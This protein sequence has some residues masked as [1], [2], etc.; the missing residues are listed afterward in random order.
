MQTGNTKKIK[1]CPW[2]AT[3]IKHYSKKTYGVWR[4]RSTL[5]WSRLISFMH[6]TLWLIFL[7]CMREVPGLNLGPETGY[8][9]RD[10]SLLSSVPPGKCWNRSLKVHSHSRFLIHRSH[11]IIHLSP[12]HSS[13]Y[14]LSLWKGVAKWTTNKQHFA[15]AAMSP[16]KVSPVRFA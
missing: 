16:G 8:P 3:L 14:N 4:Y 10:R 15:M 5:S 13:L 11:L 12:L 9:D 6:R 2:Q 1:S 7:L